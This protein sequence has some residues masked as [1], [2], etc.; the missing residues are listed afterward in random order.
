MDGFQVVKNQIKST[1]E[2]NI[3]D[4]NNHGS[5][6]EA[7]AIVEYQ[8]NVRKTGDSAGHYICDIKDRASK[9]WYRTND[10]RTPIPIDVGEVSRF[11]YVIMYRKIENKLI[12]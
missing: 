8:G 5:Q 3:R 1:E 4:T 9:Q 12:E 2:I 7:V 6:F 10:N 11:A